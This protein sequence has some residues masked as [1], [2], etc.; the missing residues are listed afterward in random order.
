MRC[1][2]C[3]NPDSRV[4]DSRP[5]QEQRVIRRRRECE[6]CGT[7]FTTY[8]RVEEPPLLVVKKDGSREEFDARKIVNGLV[9]ACERRPV[10][11]EQ[12]NELAADVEREVRQKGVDEVTSRAIGGMVMRRL[13]ALDEVAYV[14]FASVYRQFTEVEE[15]GREVERLRRSQEAPG[16]RGSQTALFGLGGEEEG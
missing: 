12:I 13:R 11:V 2:S 9:R 16:G 15:F 1:P 14:R 8:E 4:L 3:G 10:S 6:K 7:R 5:V